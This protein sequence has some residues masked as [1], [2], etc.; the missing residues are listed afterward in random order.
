MQQGTGW[1]ADSADGGDVVEGTDFVIAEHDRNHCGLFIDCRLKRIQIDSAYGL[2]GVAPDGE[3]FDRKS[4]ALQTLEAC[5]RRGVFDGRRENLATALSGMLRGAE[6]RELDALGGSAGED[7]GFRVGIQPLCHRLTA[8]IDLRGD[9]SAGF[10]AD[11][12]RIP[13]VLEHPWQH[14]LHDARVGARGRMIVEIDFA[15]QCSVT[16][17]GCKGRVVA[18]RKS[19]QRMWERPS[20]PRVATIA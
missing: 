16:F 18:N 12:A 19:R 6:Q 8:A 15:G 3:E 10:M 14:R 2:G 20:R 17:E 13:V 5:Q 7:D 1:V 9:P 4:I 11:A